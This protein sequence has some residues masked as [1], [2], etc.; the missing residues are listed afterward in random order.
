MDSMSAIRR[1]DGSREPTLRPAYP[2]TSGT[3]EPALVVRE[4][5]E[6]LVFSASKK[7]R[8]SSPTDK[9]LPLAIVGGC[10]IVAAGVFSIALAID[11]VGDSLRYIGT[12]TVKAVQ[13]ANKS[14]AAPSA[15]L[16]TGRS[17]L[18]VAGKVGGGDDGRAL[19][20]AAREALDSV[21]RAGYGLAAAGVASI[22]VG[23]VAAA[24][25]GR[26]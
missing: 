5:D 16:Q 14:A 18:M 17:T 6:V 24:K 12:G 9:Y 23:L 20:Q 22:A 15:T 11:S 1:V 7:G 10:A 13:A 3:F 2:P 25:R 4:G 26:L 8:A 21:K 19:L